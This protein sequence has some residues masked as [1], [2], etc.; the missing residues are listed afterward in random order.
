[1]T[2][3]RSAVLAILV[4]AFATVA[5]AGGTTSPTSPSTQTMSGSWVG[6]TSDS[7]GSMMG[8][9][10]SSAQM[11]NAQWRLTQNGA[12]FSGT[13]QFPGYMMGGTMTVTG[14][15]SGH[16]GTFT[17]TMPTGSIM[18]AG[19]AAIASGTFDMDDMRT[20]MHGTYSGTNSCTGA[21]DHGQMSMHR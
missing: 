21:F 12:S 3:M 17:M 13:M 9:G 20:Q 16:T 15:I 14:T 4:A 11:T 2:V 7:S 18:M 6:S 5:C 19:C 10:L 8:A 1:M